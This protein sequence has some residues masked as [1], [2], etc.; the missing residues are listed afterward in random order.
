MYGLYPSNIHIIKTKRLHY[1]LHTF[2]V[3]LLYIIH[4]AVHLQLCIFI[5]YFFIE[6]LYHTTRR[7]TRQFCFNGTSCTLFWQFNFFLLFIVLQRRLFYTI[8]HH[9]TIKIYKHERVKSS[10][11]DLQ[12]SS[13]KK[14]RL[15]IWGHMY[16]IH[17][18]VYFFCIYLVVPRKMKITYFQSSW[19]GC[20]ILITVITTAICPWNGR[21]LQFMKVVWCRA[22]PVLP[23][24]EK[25]MVLR[26]F[27]QTRNRFKSDL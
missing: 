26:Q 15:F 14:Q 2:C 12:I 25:P 16:A 27:F 11:K 20:P 22:G 8:F 3:P 24:T 9:L 13:L 19:G 17:K 4:V 18:I 1:S 6:L 23:E 10:F 5:W 7:H 21:F